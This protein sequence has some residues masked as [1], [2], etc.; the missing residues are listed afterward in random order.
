LLAYAILA[1]AAWFL[2]SGKILVTILAVLG[3]FTLKTVLFHFRPK[4]L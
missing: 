4:D 3:A 1:I 2:V